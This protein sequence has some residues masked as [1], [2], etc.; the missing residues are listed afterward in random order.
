MDLNTN[1]AFERYKEQVK[2][3]ILLNYV[4]NFVH[5]M[6]PDSFVACLNQ[7]F[8]SEECENTIDRITEYVEEEVDKKE[9]SLETTLKNIAFFSFPLAKAAEKELNSEGS[10]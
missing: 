10:E 1:A 2:R 4:G 3:I 7:I 8:N 6:Q 5:R 9:R